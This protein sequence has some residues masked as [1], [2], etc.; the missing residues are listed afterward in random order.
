MS[1]WG[2][3]LLRWLHFIGFASLSGGLLL[4]QRD[5]RSYIN[6]YIW[7]GSLLQLGTGLALTILKAKDLN[8]T[9]ILIKL[10]LLCLILLL[11]F[12]YRQKKASDKAL[13]LLIMLTLTEVAIA[14]FWQ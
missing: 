8:P 3:L 6:K 5:Q 14:V 1:N 2:L 9:K 13:S 4:Q 7:L 11:S 10:I 12:I